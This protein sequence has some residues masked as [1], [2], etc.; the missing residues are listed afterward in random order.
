MEK[1][2]TEM[3]LYPTNLSRNP[4]GRSSTS[5]ELW[6]TLDYIKDSDIQMQ[7]EMLGTDSTHNT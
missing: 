7:T 5:T 1:F 3:H 4:S 2:E 6:Q